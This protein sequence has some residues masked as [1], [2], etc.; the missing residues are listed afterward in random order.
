MEYE[1]NYLTWYRELC[2]SIDGPWCARITIW[3]H[4]NWESWLYKQVKT[5][6]LCA[7]H[8]RR[9]TVKDRMLREEQ[10]LTLPMGVG[11][12]ISP[13]IETKY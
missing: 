13:E 12:A 2:N 7:L 8:G 1:D 9:A 6:D 5:F 3:E 10:V 4:C 11:L